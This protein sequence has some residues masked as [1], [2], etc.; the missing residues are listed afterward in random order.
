M[1]TN[2]YT[3]CTCRHTESYHVKTNLVHTLYRVQKYGLMQL[4]KFKEILSPEEMQIC[5][6]NTRIKWYTIPLEVFTGFIFKVC[7]AP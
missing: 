2:L 1:S 5:L 3:I 4:D 7:I 6:N